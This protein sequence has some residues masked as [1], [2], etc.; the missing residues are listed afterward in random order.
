MQYDLEEHQEYYRSL[1]YEYWCALL[2]TIEVKYKRKRATTQIKNIA[3]DRAASLFDS[4]ESVRIQR[5]KKSRTGILRS[6]KGPQKKA[7]KHHD[8]QSYCMLYKKAGMP[9][10]MYVLHSVKDCTGMCT[11]RTIKDRMGGSVGSR[12]G[13]VKQYKK[14]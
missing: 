13:T 1:A 3:S 9:E 6:N 4:D 10:L 14:S 12:D 7:N 5:N 2:S 8:T 11:N